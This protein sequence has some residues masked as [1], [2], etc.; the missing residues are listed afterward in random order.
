MGTVSYFEVPG[1][2][3]V[4]GSTVS[5]LD[6]SG[7]VRTKTDSKHGKTFAH[8]VRWAAQIAEVPR[9]GKGAG[10]VVSVVFGFPR[11]TG[12]DRG[13]LSPCVRPDVDKLARA[14]LDALTGVAY[15]DD[16]QVVC[17][18]VRKVYAPRTVAKVMIQAEPT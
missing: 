3:G 1:P 17:L 13:R 14:L 18:S 5:F 7:K 11:P 9:I 16:G 12:R 2:Y 15:D 10:V 4:K 6:R 8:A